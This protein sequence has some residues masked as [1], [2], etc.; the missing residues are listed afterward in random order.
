M[1]D[2]SDVDVAYGDEVV[3]VGKSQNETITL[4]EIAQLVNTIPYEIL[5]GISKRVE[6]I[7]YD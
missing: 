1:V 6:R 7:Y 5:C 2:V 4:E 3:L